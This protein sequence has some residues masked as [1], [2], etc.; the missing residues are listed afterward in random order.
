MSQWLIYTNSKIR[1]FLY[2]TK[3]V[4]LYY[5]K[6]YRLLYVQEI[7][8]IFH[9]KVSEHKYVFHDQQFVVHVLCC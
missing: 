8:V 3:S 1:L 5:T 9:V 2:K 4:M 6:L 7:T